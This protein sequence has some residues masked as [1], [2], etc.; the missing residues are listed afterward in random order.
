M[1]NGATADKNDY[2]KK[3]VTKMK[4][5]NIRGEKRWGIHP[6]VTQIKTENTTGRIKVKAELMMLFE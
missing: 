2:A 1:Y 6:H 5:E 3:L 4:P